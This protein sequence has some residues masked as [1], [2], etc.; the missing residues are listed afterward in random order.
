MPTSFN[1]LI[2]V[3]IIRH[4]LMA[5]HSLRLSVGLTCNSLYN[6]LKRKQLVDVREW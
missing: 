1:S 4:L 2:M 3:L 6:E 5:M